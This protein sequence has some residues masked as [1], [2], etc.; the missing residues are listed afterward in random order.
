MVKEIELTQGKVAMVDD[1][2]YEWL[3]QFK[4]CA[5]WS[6]NLVYAMRQMKQPDGRF[7]HTKM[8]RLILGV[9]AGVQVDHIDCNGLNNVRA[10]LRAATNQDNQ[11]NKTMY[12]NNTSGFKGVSWHKH[13]QLWYAQIRLN[14]KT[15]SLGYF[16]TR[17]EAAARYD[18]A[19]HE[20][21]GD[22]A[23]P[24]NTQGLLP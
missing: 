20:L 6:G 16:S 19:A 5:S 23:R 12:S 7:R 10:N 1:A 15:I 14:G 22:F 11:H 13:R 8:H 4:W 9:A 3:N 2:D 24:N 17:E 18:L 21:F